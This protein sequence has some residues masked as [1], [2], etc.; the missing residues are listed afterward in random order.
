MKNSNDQ[1]HR[2]NAHQTSFHDEE[3]D[4]FYQ[5]I[6]L[7]PAKEAPHFFQDIDLDEN[8]QYWPFPSSPGLFKF[9][10]A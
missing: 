3:L 1:K 10:S 9:S 8:G 7:D 2:G 6:G 4:Q 5:E